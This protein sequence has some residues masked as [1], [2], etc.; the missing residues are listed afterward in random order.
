MHRVLGLDPYRILLTFFVNVRPQGRA[1]RLNLFAFTDLFQEKDELSDP[2]RYPSFL[3]AMVL[4]A[5]EPSTFEPF[6]LLLESSTLIFAI[7]C[8]NVSVKQSSYSFDNQII[9]QK[10]SFMYVLGIPF[11]TDY[12][13]F[14]P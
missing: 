6:P 3:N 9:W 11:K 8:A 1:R 10:P 14:L 12:F 4:V 13:V 2:E 5:A 7:F